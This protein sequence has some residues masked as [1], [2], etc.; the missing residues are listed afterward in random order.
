MWS[1]TRASASC[2]YRDLCPVRRRPEL[3]QTHDME[4]FLRYFVELELPMA[5]VETTLDQL[6]AE[7]LVAVA[8][9]SHDRA[10]GFM[11]EADPLAGADL[12]GAM[13]VFG[14][15]PAAWRGST[16]IRTMAWAL[17]GPHSA[18]PLLEADLEVG[19]LGNRRTQL[20]VAG[21]YYE[22][23]SGTNRRID[24][25]TAQAVGEA[26]IKEF[27]DGLADL[28]QTLAVGGSFSAAAGRALGTLPPA[29]RLSA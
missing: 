15:E 17:I 21:R 7:W 20:A 2:S 16:T 3:P 23:G 22:P 4:F 1:S 8:N 6:P 9:K 26:T 28:V 25:G 11:L 24:R 5:A 10:L 19:S 13:V 27:V 12:A 14:M 18:K 29:S